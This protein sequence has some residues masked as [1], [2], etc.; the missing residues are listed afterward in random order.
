MV[1]DVF[2]KMEHFIMCW[3]MSDAIGI[4]ILLFKEIMRLHEFPKNIN[5][6]RD[7]KYM[8]HF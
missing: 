1:V 3:T 5:S 7:T 6:D 4:S 8:G 2:S